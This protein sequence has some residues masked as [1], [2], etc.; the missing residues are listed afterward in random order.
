MHFDEYL[1]I[2][3]KHNK[4]ND[5]LVVVTSIQFPKLKEIGLSLLLNIATDH[6]NPCFFNYLFLG[7]KCN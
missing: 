3:H 5:Q 1:V 6:F 2:L 4:T 7:K